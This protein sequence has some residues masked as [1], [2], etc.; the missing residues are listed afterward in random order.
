MADSDIYSLADPVGFW[1]DETH[2]EEIASLEV[3]NESDS[4]TPQELLA[5]DCEHGVIRHASFIQ[6]WMLG[7]YITSDN[8]ETLLH[9][10]PTQVKA[11][12]FAREF[13]KSMKTSWRVSAETLEALETTWASEG[14]QREALY[15]PQLMFYV[16]FTLCAYF[17]PFWDQVRELSYLAIAEDAIDLLLTHANFT[18]K[19]S[20]QRQQHPVVRLE[21]LESFWKRVQNTSVLDN[22]AAAMSRVSL[23]GAAIRAE[24]KIPPELIVQDNQKLNLVFHPDKRAPGRRLVHSIY[25]M[26][27]IGRRE[28]AEPFLRTSKQ[29]D[30]QDFKENTPALWPKQKDALVSSGEFFLLNDSW[31][32]PETSLYIVTESYQI[33][34]RWT[35]WQ[36]VQEELSTGC[37]YYV[38]TM[39]T[40]RK[41]YNNDPIGMSIARE[42]SE[43]RTDSRLGSDGKWL[44]HLTNIAK[45]TLSLPISSP[46]CV[47]I[48]NTGIDPG[49]SP[50]PGRSQEPSEMAGLVVEPSPATHL[51]KAELEGGFID[52][53]TRGRSKAEQ[54]SPSRKRPWNDVSNL[55]EDHAAGS[56][57]ALERPGPLFESDYVSEEVLQALLEVNHF[58]DSSKQSRLEL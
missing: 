5:L 29:H 23:S 44:Q 7:L 36:V 12:K 58:G 10:F 25:N 56:G 39:D 43:R 2:P 33:P 40:S 9:S 51:S 38:K 14:R 31:C 3:R 49:N 37:V 26:H 53:S 22:L 32:P 13:F 35:A 57:P 54:K 45:K 28:P 52:L 24:E 16:K 34:D 17:T 4:G 42:P 41:E 11:Q 21:A 30:K 6:T 1:L 46:I 55:T 19:V 50:H 20:I 47:P 27:K 18:N 48:D 8:L 15:E